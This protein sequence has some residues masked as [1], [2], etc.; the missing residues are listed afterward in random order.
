MKISYKRIQQRLNII[1]YFSKSIFRRN[2]IEDV[3]WDIVSNCIKHLDFEDCVI[4]LMD[5]NRNVLVQTAAFGAKN[6]DDESVLNPI[7][8]PL[9]SGI[10]GTVANTGQSEIIKNT[11]QDKRYVVDEIP[12]LSE[13]AVPIIVKGKVYGVIDSEH[14][15]YDFY[16]QYHLEILQDLS[17]ISSTKIERILEDIEREDL[18]LMYLNNP[19]PILR[20]SDNYDYRLLNNASKNL[21]SELE[22]EIKST[23]PGGLGKQIKISFK[24]GKRTNTTLNFKEKKYSAEILPF[25]ERGYVNI[26]LLDITD[27]LNAKEQAE[28]ANLEKANFISHMSH[29]IRTPL[30]GILNLNRLIKLDTK[31]TK[32]IEYLEAIEYSGEML[33][34][35]INDILDFEKLG[36]N[37]LVFRSEVFDIHHT[38]SK[39]VEIMMP[40]AKET[41][42]TLSS[43]ISKNVPHRIIG[44]ENRLVQI[45]TNLVSN[46]LKFT[47]NG[48]VSIILK[49]NFTENQY[50][51]LE[52]IIKDTGIGI[53]KD[54]LSS[55]YSR[56]LHIPNTKVKNSEGAGLGLSIT[57]RLIE[58]QGGNIS[59]KSE[60]D[61]G[62]EFKVTLPFRISDHQDQV[63]DQP[64]PAKNIDISGCRILVVDDSPINLLVAKSTLERWSAQVTCADNGYQATEICKTEKFDLILM[65]I[66]MPEMD[67]YEATSKIRKLKNSNA[68]IP[69][70]AISADVLKV[71]MESCIELG[72]DNQISKPFNPESLLEKIFACLKT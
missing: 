8:L 32:H 43:T 67:G 51:H 37:K 39:I 55:L 23:K 49:G 70:I 24:S 64:K 28:R 33:L 40:K 7:E 44:D 14:S 6:L 68:Q 41:S 65:D 52:I 61:V 31:N 10:V 69:I 35:I 46:A 30:S 11:L 12:R 22:K 45:I 17:N 54:Q 47:N 26:C 2:T 59:V 9:G 27:I 25:S 38:I 29:E 53:P 57:K 20:V 50:F 18:L 63:I 42:N 16:D 21:Q 58:Q 72:M 34:S 3:L 4:Y 19:N 1:T 48:D 13:I 62:S 56:F 71:S 36:E 60:Q 66:Q 15:E 5:H